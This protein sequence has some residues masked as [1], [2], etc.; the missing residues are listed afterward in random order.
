LKQTLCCMHAWNDS[1]NQNSKTL[2]DAKNLRKNDG[3]F[4]NGVED[5]KRS[6]WVGGSS[7]FPI[8]N[9]LIATRNLNYCCKKRRICGL[10]ILGCLHSITTMFFSQSNH[11]QLL[12]VFSRCRNNLTFTKLLNPHNFSMGSKSLWTFSYSTTWY[13]KSYLK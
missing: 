6:V 12:K 10:W 5:W 13:S 2:R 11:V 3:C 1:N 9:D 4:Q 8:N 7:P